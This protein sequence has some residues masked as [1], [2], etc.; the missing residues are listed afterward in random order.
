MF[1]DPFSFPWRDERRADLIH[2]YLAELAARVEGDPAGAAMAI[3]AVT[4]VTDLDEQWDLI[5]DL[6]AAAPDDDQ[7]LSVIASGPLEGCLGRYGAEAIDRVEA[8]AR[9][10][11]KFRRVLRGVWQHNM[12]DAVWERVRALQA[13]APESP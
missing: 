4:F 8:E 9:R 5:L 3:T 10:D 6:I 11:P 12:S 7:V 1:F 2:T 13:V